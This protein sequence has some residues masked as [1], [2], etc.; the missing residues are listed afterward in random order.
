MLS[1]EAADRAIPSGNQLAA[2]A[3]AKNDT[4]LPASTMP[5]PIASAPSKSRQDPEMVK[6]VEALAGMGR[7]LREIDAVLHQE[8]LKNSVGKVWP[9]VSDGKVLKRIIK[10]AVRFRWSPGLPGRRIATRAAHAPSSRAGATGATGH[11]SR[12][13]ARA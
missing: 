2:S 9:T 4:E 12:D 13:R 7:S 1:Q 3:G 11:A 10:A 6:R 8:K 5:M